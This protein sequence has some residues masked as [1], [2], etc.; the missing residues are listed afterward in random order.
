MFGLWGLFFGIL[1]FLFGVFS[2]FFF[3][4]SYYHQEADLAKGG[5]FLGIVALLLGAVLIFM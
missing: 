2:V 4:S 1:L 5:I 3:P